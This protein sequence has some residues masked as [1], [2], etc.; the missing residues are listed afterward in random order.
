MAGIATFPRLRLATAARVVIAFGMTDKPEK[1]NWT[2]KAAFA[3]AAIGSAALA[4]ALLY[5]S[6]RREGAKAEKA[7]VRPEDA[8]ETD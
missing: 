1:T 2:G 3:G 7:P 8:P 5:A 4:A 6:R